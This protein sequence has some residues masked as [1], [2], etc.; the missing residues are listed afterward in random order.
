MID[1]E[2]FDALLTPHQVASLLEEETNQ[3]TARR[4]A[5]S[6]LLGSG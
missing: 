3:H 4:I 6:V 1:P 5:V 2:D